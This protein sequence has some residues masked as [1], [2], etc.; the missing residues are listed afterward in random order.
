MFRPHGA[1]ISS[2]GARQGIS[3]RVSSSRRIAGTRLVELDVGSGNRV[4]IEIP[5]ENPVAPGD[6]IA[7][8]PTRYRIYPGKA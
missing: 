3:D 2:K 7:F 4:E 8:T 6:A 5:I 1:T